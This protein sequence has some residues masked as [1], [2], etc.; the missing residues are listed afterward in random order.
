MK[1]GHTSLVKLLEGS[2]QY[3]IPI[4]QRT[5]SWTEK[6][7]KQ[8]WE[9]V[10]KVAKDDQI[11][12]HFI[13]PIVYI[14][15]GSSLS[16]DVSKFLVI[17]GQQ[18]LTT[19]SLLLTAF[20]KTL[21][22][23][24][25]KAEITPEK[26]YNRCIFNSEE[27]G[28][29]R[30][31][32]I[33]THNDK[34]TMID[35]L[36][37]RD[38]PKDSKNIDKNFKY[39]QNQ[40]NEMDIKP[41]LLWEGIKKLNI[42]EIRLDS[43]RDKPQPIFESLNYKGLE[44]S[45]AD[46]IRNYMLMDLEQEKQEE[47]YKNYWYPMEEAFG[48]LDG[49]KY[50]DQFMRDYLTIK[51]GYIP[52]IKDVYSS[53]KDYHRIKNI[54]INELI[55]DIHYFSSFFI[56][57]IF[58]KEEDQELNQIICNINTLEVNVAYPF[59]LEIYTD[60]DKGKWKIDRDEIIEIFSMVESYVFRRAI[61]GIPTYSLNKTFAKLTSEIKKER[62]LESIKAIFNLK[63]SY[64]RFPTDSE[65]KIKFTEKEIYPNKKNT[66]YFL[67]KLEN[68]NRKEQANVDEYTI[69]HIMPQNKNL[70]EEWKKDLGPNWS[71][72]QEKY[73]HVAGNLTLTGY[74]PELGD[75][76]FL[77][78]RNM[79]GGFANS[80]IRLNADLAEL[81]TWNESEIKKR[82]EILS[83]KAIGIWEFPEIS[84]NILANYIR[85]EEEDSD[86]DVTISQWH[87]KL[88]RTPDKVKSLVSL[89]IDK[90]NEKFECVSKPHSE[91]LALYV[92][93]PTVRKNRFAWL[94]CRK[95]KANVA[96]RGEPG[97]FKDRDDIRK[98]VGEV[99]PSNTEFR[100][101]LDEESIPEIIQLLEDSYN[102]T[103]SLN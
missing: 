39:F 65:L 75:K 3:T 58:E 63:N 101:S 27:K 23:K 94:Q 17:D 92:K 41:D 34:D 60:Y 6:Q 57:L 74:N 55:A 96:F 21:K 103:E 95:T 87:L 28:E 12:G 52:N 72:I 32:L 20:V 9:D 2:K 46:L 16:S 62:Y 98:R 90:I 35:L 36:E 13:G 88:E 43:T 67:S 40:I 37:N 4:Y 18:R 1:T 77:I 85:D 30:Y 66:K 51:L 70:S 48:D 24:N 8:L 22:E 93:K 71:E 86:E 33:L 42:V 15:D 78:K 19:I 26:I 14:E 49:M 59:L 100:I 56:K 89:L 97:S 80:P 81:N 47:I 61:C 102:L 5:Y 99:F 11:P 45:Q 68:D 25:E 84:D 29:K 76:S 73:V 79:E 69:E 10:I 82:T 91:G 54:S 7:C 50:F 53:F 83:D 31:K 38:G 64:R 44:L